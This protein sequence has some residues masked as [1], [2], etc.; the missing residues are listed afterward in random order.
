[1]IDTQIILISAGLGI[2]GAIVRL[3]ITFIR[4]ESLHKKVDEVGIWT[5]AGMTVVLGA[6]AGVIFSVFKILSLLGGYVSLDLMEGYY[7]LV[8]KMKVKVKS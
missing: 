2:V 4:A 1:M 7:K 3:L 8:K 6:F 5:F